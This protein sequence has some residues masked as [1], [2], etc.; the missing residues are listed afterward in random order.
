MKLFIL[1]LL[2]ITSFSVAQT[3]DNGTWTYDVNSDGPSI[4]LTGCTIYWG[5][6]P[7]DLVI[8]VVLHMIALC[9]DFVLIGL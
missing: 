4:T 2:A 3:V 7:N 6:C 5:T 1:L 8:P 9:M